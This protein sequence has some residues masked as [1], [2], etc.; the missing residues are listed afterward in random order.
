[1]PNTL[2]ETEGINLNNIVDLISGVVDPSIL[3]GRDAKIG[4]LYF[5]SNGERWKKIDIDPTDWILDVSG[6]ID[7]SRF[8]LQT[9]SILVD[10]DTVVEI[11]V[12]C[13]S[14]NPYYEDGIEITLMEA[15]VYKHQV[16][17]K[18]LSILPIKIKPTIGLIEGKKEYLLEG[19]RKYA[20]ITLQ[21]LNNNW[22][23]VS[24]V[25][26]T[27]YIPKPEVCCTH[28]PCFPPLP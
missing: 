19:N 6:S 1:M 14:C 8:V 11:D 18:N 16:T 12:G 24:V 2:F 20:S 3:P 27:Q 21:E 25:Q 17:I 28:T 4:S 7:T 23:I 9:R 22:V 10:S 5:R 15:K 13:V 26:G